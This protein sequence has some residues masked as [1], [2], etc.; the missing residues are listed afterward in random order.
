MVVADSSAHESHLALLL[1]PMSGLIWTANKTGWE[2]AGS[3]HYVAMVGVAPVCL[4]F[5][6]VGPGL[7]LFHSDKQL[8]E[9]AQ[10]S[11]SQT[12]V[13]PEAAIA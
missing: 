11:T 8:L 6:T 5:F 1:Q 10:V 13:A 7:F 4:V 3:A 12:L 2:E 9:C